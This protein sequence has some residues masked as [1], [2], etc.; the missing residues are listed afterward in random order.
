MSLRM[1][2][3]GFGCHSREKRC[4]VLSHVMWLGE[5]SFFHQMVKQKLCWSFSR[6]DGG[7]WWG[8]RYEF[9]WSLRGVL[10]SKQRV[11]DRQRWFFSGRWYQ[12]MQKRAKHLCKTVAACLL[13]STCDWMHIPPVFRFLQVCKLSMS[14]ISSNR[15]SIIVRTMQVKTTPME[16]V[17]FLLSGASNSGDFLYKV[18]IVPSKEKNCSVLQLEV[19][20]EVPSR[21]V[22]LLST[23]LLLLFFL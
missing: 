1:C 15:P 22:S 12:P 21:S 9:S 14:W 13:S 17:K 2:L 3:S 20:V 6:C 19:Q 11:R 16:P 5:E 23:F 8:Q 18:F 7:S 4:G 10:W